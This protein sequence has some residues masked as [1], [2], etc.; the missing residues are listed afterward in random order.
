MTSKLTKEQ[1]EYFSKCEYV[2]SVT[3]CNIKFTNEFKNL[4]EKM[5]ENVRFAVRTGEFTPYPNV[6]LRAGVAF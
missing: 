5:S 4:A 3:T 1:V 2:E 6:I